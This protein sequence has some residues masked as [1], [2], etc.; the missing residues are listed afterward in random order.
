VSRSVFRLY[1]SNFESQK[2][3]PEKFSLPLSKQ[4]KVLARL[5]I[6]CQA[7]FENFFET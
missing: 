4:L 1:V 7:F 5:E 6:A 3:S 2:L